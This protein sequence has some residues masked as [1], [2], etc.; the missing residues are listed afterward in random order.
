M[1]RGPDRCQAEQGKRGWRGAAVRQLA[2]WCTAH[3]LP[4]SPSLRNGC[5]PI[6]VSSS[7]CALHAGLCISIWDGRQL[8]FVL[9]H[10][11]ANSF[12]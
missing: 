5:T 11:R 12:D 9:T 8:S 7:C 6:W 1:G 2:S 4:W 3:P 10:S